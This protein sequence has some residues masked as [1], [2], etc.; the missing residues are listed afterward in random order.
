MNRDVT[1]R[2]RSIDE[3]CDRY[4]ADWRARRT[5]RLE[6]YLDGLDAVDRAALW[7]EL[8]LLDAELRRGLG[9][10][11]TLEDYRDRAPDEA[12]L[13]ELSTDFL[14]PLPP[15]GTPASDAGPGQS[16]AENGVRA[17]ARAAGIDID[18][19]ARVAPVVSDPGESQGATRELPS[20]IGDDPEKPRPDEDA[21]VG[22]EFPST[23]CASPGER[24]LADGLSATD[25]W[26]S[27][28]RP[29]PVPLP[30]GLLLGDY[31][32]IARL[33]QGGMG[34]VY[35]A[36]QVSLNRIVALKTIK[37]GAFASER[38][39]RLFQGEAEAI[40]ALDHP[41]IV[42]ILDV[43]AHGGVRFYSM[44]LIEGQD[45]HACRNR[46]RNQPRAIADL[47]ARIAE[48]IHHAHLRGVLHRDL[49][50]ANILIDAQNQPHVVD[51]GLAKRFELGVTGSLSSTTSVAGTPSYMAPEQA[52]GRHEAVTTVTDVYGLG[53]ILYAL[54]TGQPPFHAETTLQT[55]REVIDEEPKRPR[56]VDPRIDPDLETI[57]LKCLEKDPTKR[58]ASSRD[59]ADDLNRWLNGQPILARPVSRAER[60]S[61]WVRRHPAVSGLIVLVHAVGLLGLGGI[62]WQWGL[63]VAARNEALRSEDN[64]LRQAYVAKLNLAGRDWTDANIGHVRR[65]LESTVPKPGKAD[66]RGFEWYYLKRLTSLD[67]LTLTGHTRDVTSVACSRDGTRLASASEDKTIRIWDAQTGQV[68]RL[69]KE[70]PA[71]PY[72]VAFH[73]AGTQLASGDSAGRVILWDFATGQMLRTWKQQNKSIA[74][75]AFSPDAKLVAAIRTDGSVQMWDAA[76]GQDFRSFQAD[77]KEAGGLKFSPD[78]KAL[79]TCGADA[80]AK[81]WDLATGQLIRSFKGHLKTVTD[82]AFSPDGKTL[83][84]IGLDQTLRLW[85][86][87][88][89]QNLWTVAAHRRDG[90]GLAFS[91]DGAT[92][93]TVGF[94]QTLTIWDPATGQEIRALRGHAGAI[95][96]VAF[97]PD[98]TRV[99]TPSRDGTVKIWDPKRDQEFQ[100]LHD[101][102]RYISSVKFSPDGSYLASAG[103]DRVVKFWDPASGKV[104]R[105]L[106]GH[107]D[108][109]NAIA[110]SPDGRRVA[111][112]SDDRVVKVW[113]VA[114]GKVLHSLEGHTDHVFVLAYHRDGHVLATAGKDQTV[115]L[116]DP[117][118]GRL[119]RT[120]RG[121]FD[122]V[123]AVVFSPDGKL[124]A[125]GSRDRTI[126]IWDAAT[127]EESRTLKGHSQGALA[128]A[129][130][131]DG[132]R[133]AAG[134][135]DPVIELWDAPSGKL[136][137]EIPGHLEGIWTLA[138]SPDG[139]RLVSAG[140]DQTIRLWDVTLGQETFALRGHSGGVTAVAFSPDG[141]RLASTGE[142]STIKLWDATSSPGK[143]SH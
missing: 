3:R 121:H 46:F 7:Y 9:E 82:V 115:K 131:P 62:L 10:T 15:R 105:A 129:F 77:P 59:L 36:R 86:T 6:D 29:A 44:K 53:T 67:T 93:A 18:H 71:T 22:E 124:L 43:G 119:L 27:E 30:P 41:G 17:R 107:T 48:A 91:P 40:A 135:F 25:G 50:P 130:H 64:A 16:E 142:D 63:A 54:L 100:T 55:L 127:G 2:L 51:W 103:T 114:T 137:Q 120:L 104:I 1:G 143:D 117:E 74:E 12:I 89:G 5:P 96:Q 75:V 76:T 19:L 113:D 85:N 133:L 132:K 109:V 52:Q 134:S 106:T 34:V 37:A 47:V 111:S 45:L 141:K 66:L 122:E 140:G 26:K 116:W 65:L 138:F 13:L 28:P 88:T 73:P 99:I 35:K 11:P 101:H 80:T 87:A 98:G 139:S 33:A 136:I 68:I 110:F 39:L 4:E 112:V 102:V 49:K 95:F 69:I 84:T 108:V 32:L 97:L 24:A 14:A 123:W 20:T 118:T 92:L 94:G 72:C 90:L 31:E 42:P 78:R 57:C 56:T 21:T 83:A 38:E 23:E 79:A 125:S 61:K 81:L 126:R 128:L 60:I 70:L 8:V 58:Y